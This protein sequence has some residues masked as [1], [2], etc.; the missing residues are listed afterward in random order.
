MVRYNCVDVVMVTITY[1]PN[2]QPEQCNVQM[3]RDR[4]CLYLEIL[5]QSRVQQK[6]IKKCIAT[7]P[8]Y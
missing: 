3:C 6:Q 5:T 4:W 8:Q 7:L 1:H 2:Q